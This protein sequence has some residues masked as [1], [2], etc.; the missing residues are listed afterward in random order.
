MVETHVQCLTLEHN[1]NLCGIV[2][3]S[4]YYEPKAH[5]AAWYLIVGV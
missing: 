2:E 3:N 5:E 4:L 1:N